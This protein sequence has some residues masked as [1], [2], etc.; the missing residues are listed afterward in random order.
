MSARRVWVVVCTLVLIGST[1]MATASRAPAQVLDACDASLDGPNFAEFGH[2]VSGSGAYGCG[3]PQQVVTVFVCLGPL[4]APASCNASTVEDEPS[5]SAPVA[6][7]CVP[8]LW[9]ISAL[10][11]SSTSAGDVASN[12]V[13]IPECDPLEP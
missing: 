3:R 8:G 4:G 10:G 11:H 9:V 6:F 1:V 7:P 5:A 13:F 12:F 2:E